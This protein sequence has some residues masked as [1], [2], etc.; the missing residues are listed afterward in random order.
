MI[1]LKSHFLSTQYRGGPIFFEPQ[2]FF[3]S[4]EICHQNQFRYFRSDLCKPVLH[5]IE[6]FITFVYIRVQKW[7]KGDTNW[8]IIWKSIE[9]Q[10]SWIVCDPLWGWTDR[11]V[12]YLDCHQIIHCLRPAPRTIICVGLEI[13]N[14]RKS[15]LSK[16]KRHSYVISSTG[17]AI[18]HIPSESSPVT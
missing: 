16:F 12:Y 10:T 11:L 17:I 6:I 15:A 2:W 7:V 4:C 1:I 9:I 13:P 18:R 14:S 3:L 8:H 5:G